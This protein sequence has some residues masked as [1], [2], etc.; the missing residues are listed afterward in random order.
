[1]ACFNGEPFLTFVG[2]LP[3]SDRSILAQLVSRFRKIALCD[4]VD[5]STISRL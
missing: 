3:F 5:P 1:M 2:E 4:A